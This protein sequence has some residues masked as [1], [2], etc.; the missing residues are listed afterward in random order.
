M[1]SREHVELLL[2]K[3][4]PATEFGGLATTD[5]FGQAGYVVVMPVSGNDAGR[6][7][8]EVY[9]DFSQVSYRGTLDKTFSTQ[10]SATTHSPS[11]KWTSTDSPYPGPMSETSISSGSGAFN[12]PIS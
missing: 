3:R 7:P 1:K 10:E 5:H 6:L 8:R 11:P 4:R 2:A 12:S 9:S